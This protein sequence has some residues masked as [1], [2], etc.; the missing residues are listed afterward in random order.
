[1]GLGKLYRQICQD[2][3]AFKLT[4]SIPALF[5]AS[6]SAYIQLKTGI[7]YLK[8]FQ[9]TIGSRE[10]DL[11]KH[12]EKKETTAH[13]ILS[14][15]QYDEERKILKKKLRFQPSLQ[16]LFTTSKGQSALAGYLASTRICT[17]GWYIK[18]EED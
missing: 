4:P 10:E 6:Q 12:Y 3:L 15:A 11:C 18:E 2:N 7:G 5:Q 9:K 16:A 1:M 8:P 13:L 17:R 14:C